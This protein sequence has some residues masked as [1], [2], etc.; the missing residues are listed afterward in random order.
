MSRPSGFR[1]VVVGATGALGSEIVAM[2][3]E[4][5]FPV[6]ELVPV[7]TDESLGAVVE[8]RGES[9][10]VETE[11]PSLRDVDLLVLCAPP[12]ASLDFTAQALRSSV[13]TIDVSGSLVR[14]EEVPLAVA[15]VHAPVE[16]LRSPLL[17]LPV[18]PALAWIL[19]LAP[20]Q[21][22]FG[23]QRIVA[24]HLE[25]ASGGGRGGLEALSA[26]T[27]ALFNQRD[28][29]DPTVFDAPVAFD[30]VPWVGEEGEGAQTRAEEEIAV[31]LRRLVGP[32]LTLAVTAV[33]VPTFCGH[34]A[35]LALETAREVRAADAV[36]ALR[37][38]PGV[39]VWDKGPGPTTR[40]S[41]GRSE[42]L[43]GRVREDPT[44]P[45]RGLLLWLAADA[46]RLAATNAVQLAEA[47]FRLH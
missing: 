39:E 21:H 17:A 35:S 43:V 23:V 40:A 10:A 44:R 9:I 46:L 1:V 33:R 6:R 32:D 37:S 3:E 27:L 47:R 30:C 12:D 5:A 13:A 24:T 4:R 11:I 8:F 2:L 45:G 36:E 38:A 31:A 29:P 20:I 26:E 16:V 28:L 14:N 41:A 18:G 19:A 25:S 7:A 15:G 34:G 22:A 42:V